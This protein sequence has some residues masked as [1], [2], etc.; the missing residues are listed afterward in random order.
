MGKYYVLK[1]YE[2][3][4]NDWSG[5]RK[6]EHQATFYD[7]FPEAYHVAKKLDRVVGIDEC[8]LDDRLVNAYRCI[9]PPKDCCNCGEPIE[10]SVSYTQ[11]CHDKCF[12]IRNPENPF[13]VSRLK[14]SGGV[15]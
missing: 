15:K 14:I 1:S 6:S 8:K 7:S 12:E 9:G 13:V 5:W 10:E 4:F 11:H 2:G 3:F